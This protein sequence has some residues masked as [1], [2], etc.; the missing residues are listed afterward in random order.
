MKEL[1]L[2]NTRFEKCVTFEEVAS[3]ESF[4]ILPRIAFT[5]A[6]VMEKKAFFKDGAY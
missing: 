3:K 2:K 5:H 1:R 4:R 6:N